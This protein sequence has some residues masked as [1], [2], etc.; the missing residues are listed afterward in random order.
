MFSFTK[1]IKWYFFLFLLFIFRGYAQTITVGSAST[2][3]TTNPI[4]STAPYSYT[5]QIYLGSE[6]VLPLM[7]TQSNKYVTAIRFYLASSGS[8]VNS[9]NWTVY[10]G[11][12]TLST[13][14]LS[15]SW[16]PTS[17][18]TSVFSGTIS[19][20][21]AAGWL[22]ITLTNP[23]LYTGNN[24]VVGIDENTVGASTSLAS[25]RYSTTSTSYRS[26]YLSSAS[27][28]N[29][30]APNAGVRTYSRPNI[31]FD[32][33]L[34]PN[35]T[36]I[37]SNPPTICPGGSSTLSMTGGSGTT[38]WFNGSCGST[39]P[40]SIGSGTTITVNPAA[41]TTYYCR[42]YFNGMW[43]TNC[44]SSTL[45]VSSLPASPTNPTS[46]SPF[47]GSVTLSATTPPVG[48]IW[49][50][51]TS[52]SGTSTSNS[53]NTNTVNVSGTYYLRAIN[54]N[55]C[56]SANSSSITVTVLPIPAA[57]TIPL[58]N[59]P[60]CDSV[61]LT[62]A[63]FPPV[64]VQ[65]YWQ[66]TNPNGINASNNTVN[67]TV[68]S[69]ATY[70]LNAQN[71]QGCW[72]SISTPINAVIAGHPT[73]PPNPISNS[74]QCALVT[75]N[76]LN[77]PTPGIN[78]YWQST[79]NGISTSNSSSTLTSNVSG[80][81]YLRARNNTGCWSNTSA[82]ITVNVTGYPFAP[83]NPLT[84]SPH[85]DSVLLTMSG[86]APNNVTWY[87]QGTTSNGAS[88]INTNQTTP[89]FTS[90]TYYIRAR[91]YANC[92]S[93]NSTPISVVVYS[94]SNSTI[95]PS[96]CDQFLAPD[97][98]VINSS[99]QY[100]AII[101]NYL[102]C[103][104]TIQ[105]NLQVFPSFDIWNPIIAC[106]SYAWIDG[107]TYVSNNNI[108]TYTYSSIHGCDSTI[109]LDLDLGNTPDTVQIY[110]TA[111]DVFSLNGIEYNQNG[112]YYQLFT[113]QYG[114]DS[115]IQLNLI[116]E[117]AGLSDHDMKFSIYPN[118][119][120]D[121]VFFIDSPSED[122]VISIYDAFGN[123]IRIVEA[124]GQF[125]LAHLSKGIYFIRFVSE[126]TQGQIK[127]EFP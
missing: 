119:S 112:T 2:T 62:M 13:F 126:Q 11:N 111:I 71:A 127:L 40:S 83:N 75:M 27:N 8:L 47:C 120:I 97:G 100:E 18:L 41:T 24:L 7:S 37:N 85:C 99:G 116:I 9:N 80:T 51:Q 32:F 95:N 42:N 89:V 124:P 72:S 16:I 35:P 78:W 17:N 68:N 110:G 87:W 86:T 118:P 6:G 106:D 58:T 101:P 82:S 26:I 34:P 23:F 102:G 12:T 81:F 48:N 5:Q 92:W 43:S 114:C 61:T 70:Y 64:G 77:S 19:S 10:L 94:S 117:Q 59:S 44:V 25:W 60:Q 108:A 88:T 73:S 121:G 20:P 66:G 29:P 38:Y 45:N 67:F 36:S 84:N 109:H 57:P 4:A 52:P 90:G 39:I 53:G 123:I 104:S 91:N 3:I 63:S 15:S 54:S 55:G 98:Q 122:Y 33:Y 1:M 49:Y 50:W 21:P 30:S 113:T 96:A 65:W 103:D 14:A 93:L 76:W 28:P 22:T 107:N 74:P 125:S 31:Q 69:T 115:L 79:V 46:N 56:W 105:I